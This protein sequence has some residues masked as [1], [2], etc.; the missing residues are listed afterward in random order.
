MNWLI[1]GGAGFI[2]QNLIKKLIL[3][4]S[5]NIRVL[6]N[7][8]TSNKDRFKEKFPDFKEVELIFNPLKVKNTFGNIQDFRKNSLQLIKGSIT[9]EGL[10]KSI[11]TDVDVIVHLAANTGVEKS[12]NTPEIDCQINVIGTLKCLEAARENN[13]KK[14]ILASSGA[15]I[16]ELED[17]PI[18]EEKSCSPVSPYGASK[19][20]GEGYCSA[21][22]N[23]YNVNT[24]ILRFSN[25]YGPHSDYKTSLIANLFKSVNEYNKIEING[26]GNQTRD[27]IY[28]DDVIEAIYKCAYLDSNNIK[29]HKFQIAS[30]KET[31]INEIIEKITKLYDRKIE[32]KYNEKR[33]GDV[34][35]NYSSIE[36]AKYLLH[37]IPETE[38]D[39]GLKK[40]FDYFS[41]LSY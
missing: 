12:V 20:A 26:D 13:V 23:S 1:T 21:Y 39:K 27:F 16:G 3:E 24:N 41:S 32:I 38:L 40:T 31:S 37:W 14:F 28:I 11:T 5:H 6:D 7:F 19:L 8:S 34:L 30:G 35:R 25:V 33:Q 29:G 9:S 10:M 36:K 4:K 22:W 18:T 15:P 2:G 17:L